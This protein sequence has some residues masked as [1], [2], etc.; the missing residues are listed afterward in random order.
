MVKN[1]RNQQK[2]KDEQINFFLGDLEKNLEHY[3]E[4]LENKE[5]QLADAKRILI[6]AK[7]G[8][9]KVSQENRDRKAYI[10]QIK[11]QFNQQNK[12]QQL[13]F[14]KQ[15]KSFFKPKKYKKVVLEE[16]SEN[17]SESE[18]END[19]S[20]ENEDIEEEQQVTP[21]HPPQKNPQIFL[22]RVRIHKQ[23]CKET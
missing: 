3:R 22:K 21:P 9:D 13:E 20:V 8:F 4:S 5:K 11:S 16:D 14:L 23:K 18:P 12:R 15:R 1:F 19:I 7:Q 2:I 17:E 10:E 6:A